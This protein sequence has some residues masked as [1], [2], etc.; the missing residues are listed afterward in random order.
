MPPPRGL[1]VF[2]ALPCSVGTPNSSSRSSPCVLLQIAPHE[3]LSATAFVVGFEACMVHV[4]YR[5]QHLL[6]EGR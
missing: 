6:P 1:L 4:V 2:G 3:S 5:T